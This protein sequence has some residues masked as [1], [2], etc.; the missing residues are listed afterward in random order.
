MTRA[1]GCPASR[2]DSVSARGAFSLAR[3]VPVAKYAAF[4]VE[5]GGVPLPRLHELFGE[6]EPKQFDSKAVKTGN[7]KDPDKIREK[8]EQAALKHAEEQAKAQEAHDL[9]LTDQ[10]A[11]SAITGHILA[12]GVR[13]FEHEGGTPLVLGDGDDEAKLLSRFWVMY[14]LCLKQ[15]RYLVGFN[16][17]GFDLPFIIQRSFVN[18][19]SVPASVLAK[20]RYWNDIFIDLR[21]VWGCG[22]NYAKGNLDTLCRLMGIGR[23]NGDGADFARLWEADRLQ[24]IAYLD[25]DLLLTRDLALRMGVV[26]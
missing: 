9:A 23:K 18:D 6:Y 14:D 8:I 16:I 24:A 19:V 20:R 11:L 3:D 13:F 5:T 1:A 15:N 21:Q 2:K 22:N 26:I 10:A 12:I 7:L 4:D 17:H 25:N